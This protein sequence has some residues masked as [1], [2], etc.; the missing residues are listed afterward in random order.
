MASGALRWFLTRETL[1]QKNRRKN[2]TIKITSEPFT[3]FPFIKV[4]SVVLLTLSPMSFHE[5]FLVPIVDTGQ[6][7]LNL[8][9]FLC[10]NKE[11]SVNKEKWHQEV[12]LIKLGSL[13]IGEAWSISTKGRKPERIFFFVATIC[14]RELDEKGDLVSG[15][16]GGAVMRCQAFVG[17]NQTKL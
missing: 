9:N 7:H 16:Q 13:S 15:R 10:C 6:L 1:S 3:F 12:F 17:D 11:Q 14:R 4:M 8:V 2:D 5:K